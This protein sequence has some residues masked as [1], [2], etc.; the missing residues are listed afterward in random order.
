[1]NAKE[2]NELQSNTTK[3]YYLAWL[4]YCILK[5]VIL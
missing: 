3:R 5:N 4:E 1:M 2:H